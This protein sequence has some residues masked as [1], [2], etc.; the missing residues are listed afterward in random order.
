ML[1][2]F[3]RSRSKRKARIPNAAIGGTCRAVPESHLRGGGSGAGASKS[4]IR[5][6]HA[7]DA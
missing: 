3:W 7:V 2:P 1:R 6:S 5:A 4:A